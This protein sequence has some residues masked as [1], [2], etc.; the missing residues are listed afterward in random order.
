M[1]SRWASRRSV[2]SRVGREISQRRLPFL[3]NNCSLTSGALV[4]PQVAKSDLADGALGAPPELG[5][6]DLGVGWRT[7]Q[8]LRQA[9]VD[10]LRSHL[11]Q[12]NC[13]VPGFEAV[14]RSGVHLL[15]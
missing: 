10:V 4:R 2:S 14:V 5:F 1:P 3:S 12:L 15:S 13:G 9:F 11:L 6:A 7:L 8:F